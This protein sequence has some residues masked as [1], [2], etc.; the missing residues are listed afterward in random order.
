[1]PKKNDILTHLRKT[2]AYIHLC[3]SFVGPQDVKENKKKDTM[4]QRNK[5]KS[6]WLNFC[7]LEDQWT[8]TMI[9]ATL[10]N[11]Y[12]NLEVVYENDPKKNYA[13]TREMVNFLVRYPSELENKGKSAKWQKMKQEAYVYLHL[14]ILYNIILFYQITFNQEMVRFAWR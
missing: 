2:R 4:I 7:N 1:M 9:W 12:Y 14:F 5:T 8:N 11:K 3:G 6:F 10:F 13:M